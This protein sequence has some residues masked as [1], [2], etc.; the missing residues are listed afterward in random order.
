MI[1]T[2]NLAEDHG[3]AVLKEIYDRA[4]R[5]VPWRL[6]EDYYAILRQ[7]QYEEDRDIPMNRLQALVSALSDSDTYDNDPGEGKAE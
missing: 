5:R 6:V 2:T 1:M 3:L 7:Y 4:P